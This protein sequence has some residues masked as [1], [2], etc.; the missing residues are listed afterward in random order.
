MPV[1]WYPTPGSQQDQPSDLP[2]SGSS[3]APRTKHHETLKNLLLTL[4]I[5]SHSNAGGERR[6]KGASVL[7]VRSSALIL[8]EAPSSADHGGML[9]L[10]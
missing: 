3:D 9:A 7:A 8:I 1:R 4:D 2:G 10:G 5:G 6:P